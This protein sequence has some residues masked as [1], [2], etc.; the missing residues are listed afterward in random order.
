MQEKYYNALAL[1]V[2]GNFSKLYRWQKEFSSWEAAWVKNQVARINPDKEWEKLEKSGVR[3]ILRESEEYPPYLKETNTAPLGIYMKGNFSWLD[4][5]AVAIVGT[6]KATPQ[7]LD[8]AQ[9]LAEELAQYDLP[10]ISGLAL[11][12][13]AAAHAG[14]LEANGKTAA[15][16]A[17][18]LDLVYPRQNANLAKEI[19]EKG[20]TLISEYPLGMPALPHQ[21]IERNRIVSGLSRATIVIEA[22]AESGSLA[23]AHFAVEQNREVFVIPGPINHPNFSGSHALIREGARL[24]TSAKEILEDLG[25]LEENPKTNQQ[26]IPLTDPLQRK[27]FEIIQAAQTPLSVDKISEISQVELRQLQ[28]TLTFM[29]I[30]DVIK[31]SSGKY[32]I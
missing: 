30:Q 31:E 4:Q 8:L 21:F 25:L 11:G 24:A 12:I 2:E 27:I 22:P 20:G 14:A 19:L 13:D 18:G 23:T 29:L 16:L 26:K 3:L 32:F 15:V 6:R 28:S 10:I 5:N 9:K 17:T 7:G 1:S